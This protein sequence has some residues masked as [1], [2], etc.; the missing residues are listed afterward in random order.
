MDRLSKETSL[1]DTQR[2]FL[3]NLVS[4][5]LTGLVFC[6]G[7][8][9][10]AR[11]DVAED[12]GIYAAAHGGYTHLKPDAHGETSKNGYHLLLTAF[13]E[14]THE[15]WIWQAGGGLFYSRIYSKGE[16]DFPG[17]TSQT[18][19][20]Q[21]NLR[22]ESRA[23]DIEFAGRFRL[24]SPWQIGLATRTL[25]G[26]SLSFAQERD[27]RTKVFVGPQAV[28]ALDTTSDYLKRIEFSLMAD[29]NVSNRS[30]YLL[31]A[32][33]AIGRSFKP[34]KLSEGAKVLT[35]APEPTADRYEEILADKVINFPSGSSEVQ[36]AALPFLRNLGQFLRDNP[37]LWKAIAIEGH[38]DAN[39]KLAYN[40]KLSQD[41]A[42][43][44]RKVLMDQGAD[45]AKVSA[46]GFGPTK[47]LVKEDSP[48]A[49]A[50]NRRV[51]MAFTVLGREERNALSTKIKEL[52]T[53]YFG[54]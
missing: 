42:A 22:I 49:R 50:T 41:R 45:P 47:P 7:L 46:E 23:G 32:G 30:V 27:R 51:V 20:R 5:V 44:V 13:A 39:G 2:R 33:F 21:K 31:T 34:E 29:L 24:S 19:R 16:K 54:E 36:G 1:H 43:A 15:S 14:V 38:T 37:S 26:S 8:A 12:I 35:P 28:Y 48:D 18:Y 3:T 52:R 40:M 25:F 9:A 17:T 6:F 53:R 10:R 4:W 11:A